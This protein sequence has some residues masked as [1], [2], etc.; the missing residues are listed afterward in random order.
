MGLFDYFFMEGLAYRL[1][2]VKNPGAGED[3]VV[4]TPVMYENMMK[5]FYWRGLDNPSVYYDENYKRFPL[6]SRKSFFLLAEQLYKESLSEADPTVKQ[7]MARE[8]ADYCMKVMPDNPIPYDV[9]TPQFVNLYLSLNDTAKAN[10]IAEVMFKRSTDELEFLKKNRG[11]RDLNVQT[12]AFIL[13]QL[14]YAYK[15]AGINDLAKK[16]EDGFNTYYPM[17]SGGEG[18][19]Q[20]YGDE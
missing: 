7:N 1:L 19:V 11:R 17:V 12:N 20:D 8:V 6:N 10:Q 2:P 9:Y 16:Y 18:G 5:K 3:G 4:N 14:F 15:N 13:Q